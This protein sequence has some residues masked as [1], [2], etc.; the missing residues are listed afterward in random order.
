MDRVALSTCCGGPALFPAWW[1]ALRAGHYL[2]CLRV[3]GA[4]AAEH[5]LHKGSNNVPNSS[6]R[7]DSLSY[8]W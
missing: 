5:D 8:L 2:T 6:T 1:G 3:H 4:S 7:L